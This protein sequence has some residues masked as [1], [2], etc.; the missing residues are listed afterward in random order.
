MK[1]LLIFIFLISF[2]SIYCQ[3]SNDN[4]NNKLWGT[5]GI[6]GYYLSSSNGLAFNIGGDYL[7]NKNYWKLR[8]ICDIEFNIFGPE[9]PEQYYDIGL[10][11]GKFINTK[12]IRLSLSGGLG[13]L[14]G[15]K[16]GAFLYR[17]PGF[18]GSDFFEKKLIF[19]PSVPLEIDLSLVPTKHFGIGISGFA[20]LNFENTLV[21]FIINLKFGK[22]DK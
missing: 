22:L 10:L 15:V 3:T 14:G 18:L 21:G 2:P 13:V 8:L 5:L 4:N 16:R 11:Y 1:N 20:N 6:G 12:I 7:K 9:P 17:N 19:S